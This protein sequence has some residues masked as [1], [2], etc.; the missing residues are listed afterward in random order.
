MDAPVIDVDLYAA[1]ERVLGLPTD[2][3]ELRA[4]L[5]KFASQPYVEALADFH[6]LLWLSA[7]PHFDLGSEVAQLAGAVK[8]KTEVP[9]GYK[10]II[11]ALAES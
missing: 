2:K 8:E 7:Q 10:L 6:L 3:A 1:G 11:Q 4:H 9:E 5:R